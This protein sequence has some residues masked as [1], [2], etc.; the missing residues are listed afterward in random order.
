[1]D[2]YNK[3]NGP[4]SGCCRGHP[5]CVLLRLPGK[6]AGLNFDSQNKPQTLGCLRYFLIS[7][8]FCFFILLV[9]NEDNTTHGNTDPT[10]EQ[11]R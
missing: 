5:S 7:A 6:A 11:K 8:F 2:V 10:T 3:T 4:I 9:A 1:M